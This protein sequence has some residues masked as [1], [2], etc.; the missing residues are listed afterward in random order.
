MKIKIQG[1]IPLALASFLFS[2]SPAYGAEERA[3]PEGAQPVEIQGEESA[4]VQA[5]VPPLR[6][7]IEEVKKGMAEVPKP[8]K[9]FGELGSARKTQL[10]QLEMDY[11]SGKIT[12]TEY[13][14]RR[15]TLFRE[16]NLIF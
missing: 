11:A 8:I 7:K 10:D 4:P 15:D 5:P 16:A 2:V 12:Q 14:M 3:V 1:F 6:E 9:N 13:E